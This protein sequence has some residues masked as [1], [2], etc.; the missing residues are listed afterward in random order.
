MNATFYNNSINVT[1]LPIN[2][3]QYCGDILGYKITVMSSGGLRISKVVNHSNYSI[4]F[5]NLLNNLIYN[6]TVV[7]FN[8]AG[9]SSPSIVVINT[10]SGNDTKQVVDIDSN[11]GCQIYYLCTYLVCM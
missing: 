3:N 5:V 1:W 6:I 2:R 7:A 9:F 11:T 10:T 8:N 4:T